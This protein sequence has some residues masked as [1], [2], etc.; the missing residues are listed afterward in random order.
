MINYIKK[1]RIVINF[2]NYLRTK[3][4]LSESD[5]LLKIDSSAGSLLY[6]F[7][8]NKDINNVLEIG[9]WN[10]L[11]S[12]LVL[13]EALKNKKEHW[14]LMSIETDKIAY[15]LAKKN[16]K[17][18]LG[19]ILKLGRIIEINE[20]PDPQLID[21]RKHNLNPKNIEWFFQDIRRYK[22]TKNIFSELENSYD[23]ILF[24]GGEFSTFPEFKKLHLRTKYFGLDD[25]HT[26]KQ[27]DVLQ[28]IKKKPELFELIDSVKNFSI[29]KVNI[30]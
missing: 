28:Y 24:D 6:R 14:S 30:E 20:L 2:R 12:T 7:I 10:G 4:I 3:K 9:T 16:L 17:S 26:Y 11:G 5:G 27:Y 1:L 21:F 13:F 19:I 18:K 23:F 22:R 15:K 25:I 29:Y 8:K